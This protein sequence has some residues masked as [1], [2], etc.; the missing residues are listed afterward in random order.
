MNDIAV[1]ENIELDAL[2]DCIFQCSGYDFRQYARASLYRIIQRELEIDGLNHISDLIPIVLHQPARLHRLLQTLSINVTEFFRDPEAYRVMVEHVFPVLHSFPFI[3]VWHAGCATGQEVYSMAILLE[4]CGLLKR[5]LIY[6]TDF[7]HQVL[8]QAKKAIFPLRD[9]ENL[10]ERYHQSGGK[11]DLWCYFHSKYKI[12]K[13]ENRLRERI[14]FAHHN[15]ATDSV[16]GEMQLILCKN[17]LIYFN[18]ELKEKV[19]KLFDDS[20]CQGGFL[21]LGPTESLDSCNL[22]SCY[23]ALKGSR[24]VYKKALINNETLPGSMSAV[25]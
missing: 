23:Q 7:N 16:F 6:A 12:A 2:V 20:L 5:T 10:S 3:K 19:I 15:L 9:I 25:L 17:V 18:R 13:V 1:I 4:E 21:C 14:T 22:Q 24:Q 11:A 8:A